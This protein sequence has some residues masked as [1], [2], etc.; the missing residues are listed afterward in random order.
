METK[1]KQG[2]IES[3]SKIVVSNPEKIIKLL[4][5]YQFKTPLNTPLKD[6][7][8]MVV[9]AISVN[10]KF[11]ESLADLIIDG[12]FSADGDKQGTVILMGRTFGA[13]KPFFNARGPVVLGE[14]LTLDSQTPETIMLDKNALDAQIAKDAAL[15]TT[16]ETT[17]GSGSMSIGVKI[18][19]AL[20]ATAL[21]FAGLKVFKVI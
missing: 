14:L 12:K 6:L 15:E 21:I 10:K 17:L 9:S 20:G 8:Q 11:A 1:N 19:I 16:N 2:L 4:N 13:K 18:G 5:S 7:G 3:I